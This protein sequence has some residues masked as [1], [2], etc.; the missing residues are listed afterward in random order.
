MSSSSKDELARV[1]S[2]GADYRAASLSREALWAL[3]EGPAVDADARRAAAEALATTSDV[4]ERARLRIAA[5]HCADPRVRVALAE[6]A[7]ALPDG[8]GAAAGA[9]AAAS[10]GVDGRNHV[11]TDEEADR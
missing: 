1:A 7:E 5:E 9:R 10:R 4:A 3:I 11:S 2:G 6:L 8:E